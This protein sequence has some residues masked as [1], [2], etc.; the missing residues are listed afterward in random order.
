MCS[1]Q[2][3]HA[4]WAAAAPGGI[5]GGIIGALAAHYGM[6]AAGIQLLGS[7]DNPA[8]TMNVINS[9]L[10]GGIG[11][12]VMGIILGMLMKRR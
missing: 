12:G 9:L 1:G 8:A 4:C 7:G 2:A 10:E 11:G 5:L 6:G 3:W